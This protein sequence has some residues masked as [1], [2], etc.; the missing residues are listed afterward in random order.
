MSIRHVDMSVMATFT[1]HDRE[2]RRIFIL[3]FEIELNNEVPVWDTIVVEFQVVFS[4]SWIFDGHI[5]IP[6]VNIVTF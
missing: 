6:K 3:S 2:E 1:R 5:C 4:F